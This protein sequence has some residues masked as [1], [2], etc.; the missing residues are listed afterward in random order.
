MDLVGELLALAAIVALF[1]IARELRL[2]RRHLTGLA[3]PHT[4]TRRAVVTGSAD[5]KSQALRR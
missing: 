2:I 3:P 4:F 5:E 1:S